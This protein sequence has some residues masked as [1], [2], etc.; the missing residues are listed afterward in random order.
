MFIYHDG[1]MKI[2]KTM[3][4]AINIQ[5]MNEF[6]SAFLYLSMSTWFSTN[7]LPGFAHW[8]YIQ[9]EEEQEHAMK[10]HKYLLD[11]E[12]TPVIGSV[13]K[14]KSNWK[15]P[16]DIFTNILEQE[17]KVTALIHDLYEKAQNEK[18]YTSMSFL[19]WYLDEQVQEEEQSSDILNKLK[20]AENSNSGLLFLD[21]V[22]G[23]REKD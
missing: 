18:D 4:T 11:R 9:F 10:F 20:M 23:K 1:N 13:D 19:N 12:G 21:S 7:N 3:E 2:S 17:I 6:D 22:L 5:M 14:Q 15:S 8:C 16:V